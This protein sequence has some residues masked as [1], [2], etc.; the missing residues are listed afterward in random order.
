MG[1]SAW[2]SP[3]RH[4][5]FIADFLL[6]EV[7]SEVGAAFKASGMH[8]VIKIIFSLHFIFFRLIFRHFARNSLD[9]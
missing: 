7:R 5:N 2:D 4:T 9:H 3:S 8:R 1:L 6:S